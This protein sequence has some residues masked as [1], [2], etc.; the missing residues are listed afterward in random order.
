MDALHF[1]RLVVG[2]PLVL[3]AP[4]W[5]WSLLLF[6]QSG[7]GRRLDALERLALAVAFSLVVVPLTFLALGWGLG[8][9]ITWWSGLLI[10]AALCGAPFALRSALERWRRRPVG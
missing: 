10:L 1:L 6:P 4:G 5:C 9:P 3:V 2:V 8:I 7:D